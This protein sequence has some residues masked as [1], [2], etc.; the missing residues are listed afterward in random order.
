[1]YQGGTWNVDTMD[2]KRV[3]YNVY[4]HD[5]NWERRDR[6]KKRFEVVH[7]I[8]IHVSIVDLVTW[9][10]QWLLKSFNKIA[11]VII[12]SLKLGGG[13]SRWRFFVTIWMWG[14]FDKKCKMTWTT[15]SNDDNLAKCEKKEKQQEQQWKHKVNAS[16][17]HKLKHMTKFLWPWISNQ[18]W[19]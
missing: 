4:S 13:F 16:R 14:E 11:V 10:Y 5:K 2:M 8:I 7:E 3:K 19:V 6:K 9:N 1:M 17:L 12:R 15:W 18:I